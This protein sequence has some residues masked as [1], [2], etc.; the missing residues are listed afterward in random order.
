MV[1]ATKGYSCILHVMEFKWGHDGALKHGIGGNDVKLISQW[2]GMLYD[3][4]RDYIMFGFAAASKK[5]SCN[6]MGMKGANLV[7]LVG[8]MAYDWHPNLRKLFRL[9]DTSTCFPLNIRTSLPI[10][11]WP[12]SNVTLLGDAIHTMTAGRG[13]G[14]NTALR[15]A[16]LLSKKLIAMRDGQIGLIEGIHDYEAKMIKYGFDAVVKSRAQIDCNHPIH[17]PVIG[18]FMLTGMRTAMRMTNYLPPLK[19]RMEY[20]QSRFRGADREED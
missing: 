13:V 3:N 16:R 2:P 5:F 17:K 10:P 1:F 6:P 12:S 11:A 18:R 19:R 8:E 15:D 9:A 20:A 14:A 7:S 4:T